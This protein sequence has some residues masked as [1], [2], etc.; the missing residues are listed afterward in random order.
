MNINDFNWNK[1]D[2][3]I[4]AIYKVQLDI[5]AAELDSILREMSIVP[6]TDE[7]CQIATQLSTTVHHTADLLNILYKS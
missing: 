4:A 2:K 3:Q 5:V 1:S 6:R 7:L